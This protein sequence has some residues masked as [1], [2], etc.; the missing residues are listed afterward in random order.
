MYSL[1]LNFFQPG[2]FSDGNNR[3]VCVSHGNE[4]ILITPN[5]NSKQPVN[6]DITQKCV[7]RYANYKTSGLER[8]GSVNKPDSGVLWN[9]DALHFPF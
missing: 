1:E 3:Q 2:D 6:S 5:K 7:L 4:V 8:S 9:T